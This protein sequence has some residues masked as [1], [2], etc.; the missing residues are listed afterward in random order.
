M[1]AVVNSLRGHAP[2]APAA[3]MS[4]TIADA[5]LKKHHRLDQVFRHATQ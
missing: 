4:K 2:A 3:P 1:G 5:S